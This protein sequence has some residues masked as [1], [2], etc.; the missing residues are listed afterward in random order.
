MKGVSQFDVIV[1]GGGAAGLMAALTAGQLGA[2]VLLLEASNKLGKKI[3][4][5]GG[6]RC[7][8]TNLE[9]EANNFICDNPHFVKSALKQYTNW[10]F[11][12]KVATYEIDYHEKAHGQ[13]F[14]DKSAKDILAMLVKECLDGEVDS[15]LECHVSSVTRNL[16]AEAHKPK[17]FVNTNLGDFCT[18]N[19][20]VATGGLSIPSLGGATGYGYKL[21]EQ[22]GLK[23]HKTEASL[24]PMTL[25]GKWNDF[26]AALSGMH[27][28]H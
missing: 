20:I 24:V 3:L 16:E 9:V 15:R 21:A 13:L 22:F 28:I 5:S 4:M 1:L 27:K 17:F 8:F 18:S 19:L 6:G 7:N 26:S 23:V 2:S 10:D 12:S 14:C 11:I 25:A